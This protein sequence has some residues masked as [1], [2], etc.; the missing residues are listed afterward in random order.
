MFGNVN[1]SVH[2]QAIP[3]CVQTN[4]HSF[5][6]PI[7]ANVKHIPSI[8]TSTLMAL[9]QWRARFLHKHNSNQFN[10]QLY[11]NNMIFCIIFY[12]SLSFSRFCFAFNMTFGSVF[13]IAIYTVYLLCNGTQKPYRLIK[14]FIGV[15]SNA[16][17]E[18]QYNGSTMMRLNLCY[19]GDHQ[20][21]FISQRLLIYT[22]IHNTTNF[23]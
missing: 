20:F 16:I 11:R 7:A 4:K 19:S 21:P 22:H 5:Y 2:S 3:K 14:K 9:E 8:P 23:Y 6:R 13:A 17:R 15:I 18:F 12:L 1:D 10:G